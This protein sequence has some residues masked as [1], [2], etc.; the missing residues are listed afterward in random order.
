[1]HSHAAI[2]AS[3]QDWTRLRNRSYDLFL[4]VPEVFTREE[5]ARIIEICSASRLH[6]G[7]TS[8]AF[9]PTV[10]HEQRHVTAAYVPRSRETEWIYARMDSVFH[11]CAAYWGYDVRETLE[12]LKYFVYTP[13]CHFSQWH[14]DVGHD[15]SNLRKLTMSIEL[16][17][18]RAYDG[19]EL[20]I[21]P[22]TE[23]HVCGPDRAAGS[24]AV[25]PSHRFHRVTPVTCGTR[26]AIVN[27]ISGPPLR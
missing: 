22:H 18:S 25:F 15:Y 2:T 26:Y 3:D 24:A 5:C 20:Q 21:F 23:G 17:D 16:C 8:T 4:A 27:W 10:D 7:E 9:G 13:G 19:G 12:D 6:D 14:A 1:M 11:R